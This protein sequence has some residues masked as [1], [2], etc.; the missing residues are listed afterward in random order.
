MTAAIGDDGPQE[1]KSM[2]HASVVP[3]D[4]V[5]EWGSGVWPA[6]WIA[7]PDSVNRPSV[8]AFCRR[9]TLNTQTTLRVHVTADERYKLYLD[10][11]LVGLGP[12]RCDPSRWLYATH[13]WSLEPGEHVV[14]ALVWTL[15]PQAPQGQYSVSGGRFLLAAE[16]P[17]TP[18]LTT[19]QAT[20]TCKALG[21]FQF[22]GNGEAWGTG[23]RQV[24]D[25]R[26][27]GWGFEQGRGDGWL[28]AAVHSAG[29]NGLEVWGI[30]HAQLSPQTLP[31]MLQLQRQAGV[32]RHASTASGSDVSQAYV[33]PAA[34]DH[35]LQR[36]WNLLL[37]G[38]Q[39]VVVG[40]H[41]TQR[42]IIDLQDYYCGYLQMRIDGGADSTVSVLWAESLYDA[43]DGQA[44]GHR[45]QVD[46][47]YFR[48][49]GNQYISDGGADRHFEPL[50]WEAGR[51]LEVRIQTDNSP[52][53]IAQFGLRETRYP[54]DVQGR[55]LFSDARLNSIVR[56]MVRTLEMCSHETYMD[57]PYY[58]QLMYIGDSRTEVLA[59]YVLT[60]D[61]RLPRRALQM[62][63]SLRSPSGMA[64][65]SFLPR[66]TTF[67]PGFSLWWIGMVYDFALWRGDAEFIRQL[68][69]GV[70]A[71]L[72]RCATH[73]TVDGVIATPDGWHFVDWVSSWSHGTPAARNGGICGIY[74][75]QF[76]LMLHLAAELEQWL[77]ETELASRWRRLHKQYA[78][79]TQAVFWDSKRELFA[80]DTGRTAWSQ[81]AQCLAILSGALPAPRV[82]QLADAMLSDDSLAQAT[83]YFSHYVFAALAEAGRG[84]A[85]VGRL[86]PWFDLSQQGFQTVYES[87]GEPRSDCHAWGSH[88]LY[89]Y[90]TALLGIRPG[91]LGFES[92]RIHPQPGAIG[93][94]SGSIMHP[95]AGTIAVDISGPQHQRTAKVTLPEGLSGQ[96]EFGS[97]RQPISAGVTVIQ[98]PAA[99][100]APLCR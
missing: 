25:A 74:N 36:Q 23:P 67:I 61:D 59:T 48:G 78:Q 75:W 58:E 1:D 8:M 37:Q 86:A 90:A 12:H 80:D 82:R 71:T 88:P 3:F 35:A 34:N 28:P 76:V 92:V 5:D 49:L 51:Y 18:V 66:T 19:G 45:D 42:I 29:R 30:Q 44:K 38:Q 4:E 56:P 96:F 55:F 100:A 95:R 43:A 47:K 54:L 85:I 22:T 94:V 41:S 73:T 77:G 27:F 7:A 99:E 20:W 31:P 69:P 97:F 93:H 98:I 9:F 10:G 40:P 63:D 46:G 60:G 11:E 68:M 64:R 21:G 32:V 62:F 53:T 83:M 39:P 16:S 81:H 15:G 26:Q 79:A 87:P 70:R 52:L 91:G 65:A 17:H 13:E 2:S 33:D 57:C 50:W 14:V 84:D 6:R 89:H 24:L 72:D